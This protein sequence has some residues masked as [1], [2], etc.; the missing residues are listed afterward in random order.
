[1]TSSSAHLTMSKKAMVINF[2]AKILPIKRKM[3]LNKLLYVF[4]YLIVCAQST[5]IAYHPLGDFLFC[6]GF[7]APYF[8]RIRAA[9][10]LGPKIENRDQKRN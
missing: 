10:L 7:R 8:L 9:L 1:M 5:V 3:I 2:L 6:P 4:Q